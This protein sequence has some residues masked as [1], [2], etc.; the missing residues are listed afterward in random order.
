[1]KIEDLPSLTRQQLLDLAAKKKIPVKQSQP[2][3]ELVGAVRRGLKKIEKAKTKKVASP[4][5]KKATAKTRT[6]TKK[7]TA[8]KSVRKKSAKAKPKKSASKVKKSTASTKAKTNSR[9]KTAKKIGKKKTHVKR[10][11]VLLVAK[12]KPAVKSKVTAAPMPPPEKTEEDQAAKFI[13][14]SR[15]MHDEAQAE[16]PPEPA[17]EYGDH[18][19][20]FLPRDP[21]WAYTY[22]ELQS[23]RI[24]QAL[25]SLGHPH[26]VNWMLRVYSPPDTRHQPGANYFDTP[27]D[28]HARKGYLH[29]SPPGASFIAELGVIA[30]SGNFA[31][32]AVSNAISLPLDRPSDSLDEEWM[33]SPEEISFH[34]AETLDEA[35]GL[36]ERSRG[37]LGSSLSDNPTSPRP[38]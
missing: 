36:Y 2:K 12:P 6:P 28:V 21:Y 7:T 29:L 1:M 19:L 4:K 8:K 15:E 37:P 32:V 17:Q 34:Y 20:V 24:D 18:H 5:T 9:K 13:L 3:K 11:A 35:T 33:L 31:M 22:W 30:P 38:K 10:K 27:I 25:A 16:A 23:D 26:S 14:G